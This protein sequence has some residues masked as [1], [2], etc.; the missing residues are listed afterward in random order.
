[1]R[2]EWR[3]TAFGPQLEDGD[4]VA[5]GHKFLHPRGVPVCSSDT[6]VTGSAANCF[7]LI[8]AV[9]A[10]MRLAQRHP[11]NAHWI[12]RTGR[13]NECGIALNSVIQNAFIVAKDRQDRDAVNFPYA[14]RRGEFG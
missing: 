7:R 11:Q 3:S 8:R 1:M 9:D 4:Y 2:T 13:Q 12:I 5:D 14:D 6:A 10:D